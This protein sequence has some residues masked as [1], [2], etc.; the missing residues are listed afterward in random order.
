MPIKIP[1]DLPARS[2]LEGESIFVMTT[3]RAETQDIRP[4]RLVILNLMP[5]KIAT[6]T[7][8]M[9]CLSNSP[10]QAEIDLLQTSSHTAGNTSPE[11]LAS[12]YKTFDEIRDDRYDGMIITGA[13]V[14][15]LDFEDVDYWPELTR[16]L[17]W[18]L[19]NVYSTFHICWGAQAGLYYHYGV[20]KYPLASKCF[21]V[22]WHDVLAPASPLFRGFDDAFP[23]PHSRHTEVRPDDIMACPDLELLATSPEAGVHVCA[24]R[25]L[26]QVFVSGH[27]EYD[28]D[29]LAQEYAR[30]RDRGLDIEVPVG[31]FPGD[32]PARVPRMTW[33]AHASL[34]YSNWLNNVVYQDTPYHLE[35]LEPLPSRRGRS[36]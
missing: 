9:R 22:Y 10:I 4:V 19:T 15:H 20:R 33:R 6:E 29:T 32:D 3:R 34:L 28:A 26:R 7:Q 11:H 14:E 30:D 13:P 35:D 1:E 21:G 27:G 25:G 24:R 8:L 2:V 17:D 31:Y 5:T 36:D 12:F 18:T 16:I 23:A